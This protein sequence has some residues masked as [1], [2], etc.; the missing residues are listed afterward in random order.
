MKKMKKLLLVLILCAFAVACTEK[1]DDNTS[2]TQVSS[3]DKKDYSGTITIGSGE[4]IFAEDSISIQ[5]ELLTEGK[6]N[7]KMFQVKFSPYMP[8]RIDMGINGVNYSKQLDGSYN[9]SADSI[10]PIAMGGEYPS[11]TITNLQ[12]SLTDSSITFEMN[13][14]DYPVTYTGTIKK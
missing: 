12:G 10:V 8:V 4:N 3:S 13:C 5:S 6:M 11:Y 14:G 2:N 9:I 1:D 7:L